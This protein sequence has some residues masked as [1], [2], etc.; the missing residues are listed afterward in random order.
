M[1]RSDPERE[2]D[3]RM[4]VGIAN[5][6]AIGLAA[7][8]T[9][10][11]GSGRQDAGQATRTAVDSGGTA[12]T[13]RTPLPPGSSVDP[14]RV[15]TSPTRM[16]FIGTSLTA[17]LGLEDVAAQAWPGQIGRIADS[18]GYRVEIVNA[19]LSGETSAGALRRADWLLRDSADVVVIETGANDGLRGLSPEQ[20]RENLEAL[21]GKVKAKLPAA[22]LVIVQMEAPPNLGVTYTGAFRGVFPAVASAVGATLAP[23]LLEGVAGVAGM[24]QADGIHPTEAGALRAARNVWPTLRGVLDRRGAAIPRV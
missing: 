3:M 6:V 18:L 16:L 22:S 19:G 12:T 10:C 14:V 1:G 5:V 24:N 8:L 9:A 4:R 17:G 13:T 7:G 23:F 20:V 2:M 15:P 11:G 21:V